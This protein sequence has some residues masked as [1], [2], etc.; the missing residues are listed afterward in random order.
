[1]TEERHPYTYPSLDQLNGTGLLGIEGRNPVSLIREG[2]ATYALSNMQAFLS[3]PASTVAEILDI[4]PRTFARR[5]A[6]GLLN[7]DESDRLLRLARLGEL[8]I[9]VFEDREAAAEWLTSPKNLL[10]GESPIKRAD[11]EPGAREVEAMLYA[12]EFSTAA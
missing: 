4:P 7:P 8:A 6:T 10:E 5:K 2:V 12:I 11:T 9:A 1:M 3:I